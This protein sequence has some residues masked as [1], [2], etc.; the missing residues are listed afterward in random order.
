MSL[1]DMT[2]ND[3]TRVLT[4]LQGLCAKAEYCSHDIYLK[5]LKALD[6]DR[7]AAE[8]MVASL[9]EDKFVDDLR[10]A[11]AFAREKSSLT[12]WGSVKISFMLRGKGISDAVIKEALS[13]V[14][15]EKASMKLRKMAQEKYRVLKEDPECRL[16]LLKSLLSRGYSYDEIAPVVEEVLKGQ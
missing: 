4:R 5:A 6:G 13:S 8:R 14:E 1:S 11:S 2:S 3:E 15:P 9:V 16:K 7:E 12:G 10:Y